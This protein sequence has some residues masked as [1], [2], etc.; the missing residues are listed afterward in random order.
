MHESDPT[1]HKTG[2][3]KDFAFPV[4]VIGLLSYFIFYV[5][6]MYRLHHLNKFRAIPIGTSI[7]SVVST[8]GPPRS[9]VVGS[10]ATMG[11]IPA[12]FGSRGVGSPALGCKG[13]VYE[14]PLSSTLM[15]MHFDAHGKFTH[16]QED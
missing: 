11:L 5:F 2:G 9:T 15:V 7:S 3:W 12:G 14:I 10:S 1:V 8:L 4:V 16:L 6:T 13:L